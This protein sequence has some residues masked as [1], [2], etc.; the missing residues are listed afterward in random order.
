MLDRSM[1]GMK[2]MD[3]VCFMV[4]GTPFHAVALACE[5]SSPVL[6]ELLMHVENIYQEVIPLP[7]CGNLV[8]EAVYEVCWSCNWS[9]RIIGLPV[10]SL[11]MALLIKSALYL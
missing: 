2:R 4:G 9:T 11:V 6:K 1:V 3:T 5:R 8:E 7:A 10:Q